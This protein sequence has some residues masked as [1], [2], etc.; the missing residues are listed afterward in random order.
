VNR[1]AAG[2]SMEKK[3][4]NVGLNLLRILLTLGVVMD[5][6]WWIPDASSLVGFDRFLW[7]LR[8]LAVPAFM[9]MTFLFAAKRFVSGDRFGYESSNQYFYIPQDLREKIAACRLFLEGEE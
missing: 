1:E 2:R 9:T 6:F 7:Q 4:I 5:H 3:E 8:T